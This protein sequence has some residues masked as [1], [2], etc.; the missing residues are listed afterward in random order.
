M[1]CFGI[2]VILLTDIIN[3]LQRRINPDEPTNDEE[4]KWRRYLIYYFLNYYLSYG[5][6]F[7]NFFELMVQR[8]K[9]MKFFVISLL[10]VVA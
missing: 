9:V 4:A 8:L 3:I 1:K 5:L 6:S 10:V 2:F 7:Q